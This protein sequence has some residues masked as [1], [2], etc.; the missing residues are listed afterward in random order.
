MSIWASESWVDL[1]LLALVAEGE[2][3]F[4]DMTIDRRTGNSISS[5]GRSVRCEGK[6]FDG[7]LPDLSDFGLLDIC[8]RI[9]AAE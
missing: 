4:S 8:F 9:Q 3:V 2:V 5:I 6:K 7:V 1:L